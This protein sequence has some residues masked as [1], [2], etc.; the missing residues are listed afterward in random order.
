[1]AMDTAWLQDRFLAGIPLEDATGKPMPPV[2]LEAT[3]AS[4]KRFYTRTHGVLYEP[5]R[6]IVGAVPDAKCPAN[7]DNEPEVTRPGIDYD[8]EGFKGSRWHSMNLPFGPVR[9]FDF[10]GLTYGTADTNIISF[11]PDWWRIGTK[12]WNLR[13]FPGNTSLKTENMSLASYVFTLGTPGT[14]RQV[15]QGWAFYYRAGYTDIQEPD[16]ATAIGMKAIVG[17]LPQIAMLNEGA[18]SSESVSVDGLSQTRSYPTSAQAH[19]YSPLQTDFEKKLEA[20]NKSFFQT[21]RGVKFVSI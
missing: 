2:V 21:H 16:L 7:P 18:L 11:P 13:L 10:V 8:L 3:L 4:A 17:A 12:R 5:T 9:S 19:R 15:P 6:V 14:N 1:M 20:F